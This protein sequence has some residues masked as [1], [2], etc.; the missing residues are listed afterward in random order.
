MSYVSSLIVISIVHSSWEFHIVLSIAVY[1]TN[2]T[3]QLNMLLSTKTHS[4]AMKISNARDYGAMH[5]YPRCN[6]AAKGNAKPRLLTF[7]F[8][9]QPGK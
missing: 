1:V 5:Q 7:P 3:L 8:H 2:K 4:E 9:W 6:C